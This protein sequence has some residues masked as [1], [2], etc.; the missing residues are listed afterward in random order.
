MERTLAEEKPQLEKQISDQTLISTI[1]IGMLEYFLGLQFAI[2][3]VF[4]IPAL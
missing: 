3:P 2:D 1:K 4:E